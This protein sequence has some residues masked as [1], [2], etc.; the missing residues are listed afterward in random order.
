[1]HFA[2]EMAKASNKVYFVNPPRQSGEQKLVSVD[3]NQ[4]PDNLSIIN[5]KPIKGYLFFRYKLFWVYKILSN[6]YVKGIK[7]IVGGEPDEVWCFNPHDFVDLS[8]FG[9][10]KKIVLLYDLYKGSHIYKTLE[11][12]DGL[13]SIS[14]VILDQYK[15]S[16]VPKLLIQH[17]LSSAFA[18]N[19]N[20][21][22][23]NNYFKG[24]HPE[25]IKVGYTG[26]LVRQSI[27]TKLAMEIIS[28]HPQLEFHFWGPSSFKENNV[29]TSNAHVP[30][31]VI[32]FISFLESQDNVILHGMKDQDTLARDLLEMDVFLFLYSSS[33]DMNGASNSH[34][35][36][37]YLSTG[38]VVV[39]TFVS[40][41]KDYDLLSM[42]KKE[43]E[44]PDLFNRVIENLSFY[45]SKEKQRLRIEFALE[46]KYSN[47]IGKIR[48]FIYKL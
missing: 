30:Q 11:S 45:N 28:G 17:G 37:E 31:E 41:Y 12:S 34:K 27:N 18:T 19:A 38:K 42:V 1:M 21:Y 33:L 32:E 44:L 43:E 16:D 29:T 22:L 2:L 23:I 4:T 13:V 47:Q 39:S 6:L 9:S 26:N 14:Q 15:G 7:K 46:N 35:L 36:L 40:N 8:Q 20:A 3:S 10:G 24:V 48:E 25:K 5:L